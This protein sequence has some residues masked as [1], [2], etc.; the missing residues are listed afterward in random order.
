M[1]LHVCQLMGYEQINKGLNLITT[2]SARTLNLS[3]YGIKCG[4]WANLLILPAENG[5]DAI[6]R[7]TPPRYVIRHGQ[8]IAET[9]SSPSR[10]YL[11]QPESVDFR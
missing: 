7:Q 6:R 4:Y 11:T 5:F 2:N 3:D 10:L 1:G 9:P 8:V